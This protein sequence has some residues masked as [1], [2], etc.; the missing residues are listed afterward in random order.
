M[1][2]FAKLGANIAKYSHLK[3]LIVDRLRLFPMSTTIELFCLSATMIFYS[4]HLEPKSSSSLIAVNVEIAY[5]LDWIACICPWADA[6][7]TFQA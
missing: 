6:Y 3:P 1:V 5:D 2:A 4:Y 7:D